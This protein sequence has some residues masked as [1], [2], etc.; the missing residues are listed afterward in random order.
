ME[1]AVLKRSW[2]EALQ[3]FLQSDTRMIASADIHSPINT[4]A[5]LFK[6]SKEAYLQGLRALRRRRFNSALGFDHVGMPHE[7]LHLQALPQLSQVIINRSWMV[8]RNNW[9]FVGGHACQGLFV[10]I[11]LVLLSPQSAATF[12]YPDQFFAEHGDVYNATGPLGGKGGSLHRLPTTLP[13][14]MWR[15]HH[16]F[17]G[18]KPW[19]SVSR[20]SSYFDF[21]SDGDA[22]FHS[23]ACWK[24]MKEKRDCLAPRISPMLCA[25]CRQRGLKTNGCTDKRPATRESCPGRSTL[26]F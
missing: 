7:V 24:M 21:M 23:S 15:V 25:S 16:F 18:A 12:K 20:C 13:M 2:T 26:L 9:D 22:L 10:Y 11:Y 17:S 14:A 8:R 5:M 3:A 19:R 1:A 4:G 6:P